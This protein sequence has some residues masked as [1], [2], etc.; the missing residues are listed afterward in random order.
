M[1]MNIDFNALENLIKLAER[2]NIYS[3]EITDKDE[4][5]TIVCNADERR[6]VDTLKQDHPAERSAQYDEDNITHDHN[7]SSQDATTQDTEQNT[8][9]KAAGQGY[10]DQ[11]DPALQVEKSM[12]EA[13][14]IGTFY[15]RSDP[16]S[17]PLVEVGDRVDSGQTLCVI[18]AMKIMNEIKAEA[19]CVITEILVSDNDIVEYGQPLFVIKTDE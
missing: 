15:R 17:A 16:S 8:D 6:A 19:P 14:M 1:I 3:L 12:I 10:A 7:K 9:I 2:S 13:P 5:I 4:R 18:E 11:P